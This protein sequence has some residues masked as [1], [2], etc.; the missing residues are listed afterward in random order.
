MVDVSKIDTSLELF[1][2][3]LEHPILLGPGGGK[4][5]VAAERREAE[6]PGGASVEGAHGRRPGPD[7]RRDGQE[8]T[9]PIWWGATLGEGT[10]A[11]AV[12]SAKR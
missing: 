3:K 10:Q 4:N 8:G 12:E 7:A 11:Q 6:R 1:G 5:I 9:A 2:Q